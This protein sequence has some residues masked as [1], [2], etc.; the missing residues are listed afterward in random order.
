MLNALTVF[1]KMVIENGSKEYNYTTLEELENNYELIGTKHPKNYGWYQ[2][3]W[4]AAAADVYNAGGVELT[5][6]LW[7]ALAAEKK[8]LSDSEF[9]AYMKSSG[10][11][12]VAGIMENWI[13]NTR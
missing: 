3:R 5:R 13:K 10:L 8:D 2:S 11:A 6:R 9:V 12:D 7:N 1:P 4:H